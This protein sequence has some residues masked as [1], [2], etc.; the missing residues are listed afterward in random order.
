[1]K[2]ALVKHIGVKIKSINVIKM[3]SIHLA[4]LSPQLLDDWQI[5]YLDKTAV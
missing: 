1:M 5:R 4:Y 3:S 2:I